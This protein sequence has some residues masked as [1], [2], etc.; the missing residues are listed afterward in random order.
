MRNSVLS[1][2]FNPKAELARRNFI[3]F[4]KYLK[5]DYTT[6]WFHEYLASQLDR[7]EKGE[8]KKLM[9]RMPPQHGKSELT[10]RKF[11]AYLQGKDPNRLVAVVSY[12]N[13]MSNGFNRAIQRS[14]DCKEFV[15]TFPQTLINYSQF[16]NSLE[17]GKVRNTDKIDILKHKG[18]IITIGVGGTLTGNPVD[19]GIIDDPYKDREQAR[20][21]AYKQYLREWYIDVF[22]TRL[23]NDSQE[24]IIMTSWDEDDLCQWILRKEKDWI[25]IKFPA[26]KENEECEYDPREIGQALWPEKHSLERLLSIKE[27]SQV[28]FNALYQQD[29]KPNTDVLIFGDWQEC[30]GLPEGQ[31]F[32]GC[33]FGYTNDPTAITKCIRKDDKI[34][35]KECSYF[36]CGD[37]KGIKAILLANGYQNEP[38]YCD[39]DKELIAAL[40]REG[41]Y[42]V[43]ANKSIA[44]GIAKVKSFK[45][46]FT[47]DSSNIRMETRKY[48]YI[49]Y[50]EVI[51]NEPAEGY[52]HLC[53]SSRYAI[54]THYFH[55]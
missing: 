51:T 7:F 18:S 32:W 47:A 31:P 52:D 15:D 6:K 36:P 5:P 48:Q 34:Y 10:T 11:P 20:S 37:E 40:R 1:R 25:D 39:H 9:V 43:M 53:D 23:H 29:P 27:K 12:N 33:D 41:V 14:L 30:L 38:V 13:I 28:T 21:E 46:F 45:V 24:L 3:D 54:Y 8:I 55:S 35:I 44:A 2:R 22:R 26:I 49:T 17:P 19:I 4:V 16:H 42:A 50:G